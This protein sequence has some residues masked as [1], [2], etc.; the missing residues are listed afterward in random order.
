M[1]LLVRDN[2]R[3][4]LG[5]VGGDDNLLNMPTFTYFIQ[6]ISGQTGSVR[7]TLFCRGGVNI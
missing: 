2:I 6:R 1:W 3:L 5:R 7:T 4:G